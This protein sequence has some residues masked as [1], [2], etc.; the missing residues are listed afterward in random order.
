VA[1]LS[2]D[3][4]MI[5]AN[6]DYGISKQIF[7]VD[8]DA[9]FF[10]YWK[11]NETQS[12]QTVSFGPAIGNT[13]YG[14]WET[15]ESLLT[16]ANGEVSLLPT[17]SSLRH[18]IKKTASDL[19]GGDTYTQPAQIQVYANTTPDYLFE[20]FYGKNYQ[21]ISMRFKIKD[22]VVS[23]G[24]EFA[25]RGNFYWL[26]SDSVEKNAWNDSGDA[27]RVHTTPAPSDYVTSPLPNFNTLSENWQTVNWD[28]KG[29]AKTEWNERIITA[30]RIDLFLATDVS[31]PMI[32]DT[33]IDW[34]K[35]SAN[36][37]G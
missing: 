8:Q 35:I 23:S 1:A 20:P 31:G 24:G 28:M 36:T 7:N 6:S 5:Q 11:F 9:N 10:R 26:T 25:W 14:G 15:F 32:I 17:G 19:V 2:I 16:S 4:L 18:T 29:A 13:A 27:T 34:I 3:P 37:S 21:N 33:D 30:L 22:N 12:K